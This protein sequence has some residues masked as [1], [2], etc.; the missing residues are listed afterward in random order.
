MRAQSVCARGFVEAHPEDAAR[1]IEQ[2]PAAE[3][4][5]F[6][7]TLPPASTAEVLERMSPAAGAEGLAHLNPASGAAVLAA[8]RP[9]VAVALLRRVPPAQQDSLLSTLAPDTATRFKRLLAYPDDTVGSI[10]DP[11]VLALPQ[12]VAANEGLRQLR[13]HRET[14]HHHIYVVDRVH[15]LVGVLHIRDLVSANPKATLGSIMRAAT[16]GLVATTRLTTAAAH[17]AWRALDT[18]PVTDETGVLLGMVRYR[19]LRQL[20]ATV[21]PGSL[22]DTI[23]GLGELYWMGLSTFLPVIPRDSDTHMPQSESSERGGAHG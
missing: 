8:L 20:E 11:G 16:L 7:E 17:P 12:D 19:Q 21:G 23:L 15:Q 14:A 1:L 13:R 10:T 2:Y 3:A 18:L 4:V 22:A 6:L 9:R 5:P